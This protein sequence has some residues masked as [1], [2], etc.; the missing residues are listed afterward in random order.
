LYIIG[1]KVVVLDENTWQEVS[2]IE[3]Q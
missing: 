2:E 3:L 1:D